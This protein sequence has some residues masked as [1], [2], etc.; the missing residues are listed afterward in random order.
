MLMLYFL[1]IHQMAYQSIARYKYG[2][3]LSFCIYKISLRD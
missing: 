3:A 1:F 2:K